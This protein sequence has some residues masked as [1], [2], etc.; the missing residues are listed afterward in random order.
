MVERFSGLSYLKQAFRGSDVEHLRAWLHC[1][2]LIIQ[3]HSNQN[4]FS[5]LNVTIISGLWSHSSA[6]YLFSH[7]FPVTV[8]WFINAAPKQI[9]F[10][11]M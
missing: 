10:L 2:T 4:D 6:F 1:F 11:N 3:L 9:L 5:C 8:G 7:I